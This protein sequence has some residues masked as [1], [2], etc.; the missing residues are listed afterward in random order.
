MINAYRNYI[1]P[2][3]YV[4][5]LS[6]GHGAKECAMQIKLCTGYK[7]MVEMLRRRVFSAGCYAQRLDFLDSRDGQTAGAGRSEPLTT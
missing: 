4:E 2:K 6:A 1:R 5:R 7:K 3:L